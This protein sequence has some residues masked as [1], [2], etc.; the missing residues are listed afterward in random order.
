MRRKSSDATQKAAFEKLAH[1][2]EC[3]EDEEA[4]KAMLVKVAKASRVPPG[5]AKSPRE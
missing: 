4:F 3:D 5:P 1:E 2:L